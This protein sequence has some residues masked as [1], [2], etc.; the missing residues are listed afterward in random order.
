MTG[1]RIFS[2]RRGASPE[3]QR[4]VAAAFVAA[5]AVS[6]AV[7]GG[8][9]SGL[10]LLFGVPAVVFKRFDAGRQERADSPRTLGD[11]HDGRLRL[12]RLRI[13]DSSLLS[14]SPRSDTSARSRA[15]RDAPASVRRRVCER[16]SA[17][18]AAGV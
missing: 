11:G 14:K 4:L 3:L 1:D 5:I 10:L 2:S 13:F 9:D 6:C 17:S 12:A 8:D 16:Y 7:E 15:S 18:L